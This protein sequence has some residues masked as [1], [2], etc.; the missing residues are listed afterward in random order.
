MYAHFILILLFLT[1]SLEVLCQEKYLVLDKPGRT[2]R[3]RYY[4]GDEIIFKLKGDKTVYSNVVEGVGDSSI[5]VRG[6]HI[7]I[8]EIASIIRHNESG[9]LYQITRILPK[10]GML[11]FL[12]DTFN[13][14]FRGE[15]PSV[16]RSGVIVGGS[17]IAG[18][19]A[20]RLF[21]KRTLKIN[22]YRTLKILQTF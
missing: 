4:T 1:F 22:K 14:I 15:K 8:K 19:Y 11:Y 12:A 6:T 21:K 18:S 16:S 2:K 20:L 3:I 10:A 13:P 5:Q 9:L 17:L 7:P